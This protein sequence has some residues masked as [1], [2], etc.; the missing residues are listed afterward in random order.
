[1]L[2]K[3]MST[4][5]P[6]SNCQCN[7]S[8]SKYCESLSHSLT[9]SLTHSH[10]HTHADSIVSTNAV[11]KHSSCKLRV[12]QQI[13]RRTEN[14]AII[15]LNLK[16]ATLDG[17]GKLRKAVQCYDKW[18]KWWWRKKTI[19]K[20]CQIRRWRAIL[21][22]HILIDDSTSII[23]HISKWP[24]GESDLSRITAGSRSILDLTQH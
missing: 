11:R 19:I 20:L 16:S 14:M 3:F 2:L 7:Y 13:A 1:M 10:T 4:S 9:Q 23:K 17:K 24:K 5:K 6:A 8:I 21:W 15:H 22:S 18:R 12:S